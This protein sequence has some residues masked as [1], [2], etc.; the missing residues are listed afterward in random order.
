M[1]DVT[2]TQS[3]LRFSFLNPMYIFKFAKAFYSAKLT[4]TFQV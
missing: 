1:S 3:A 2:L 4:K